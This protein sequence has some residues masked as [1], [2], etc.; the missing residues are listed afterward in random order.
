M[1]R[2]QGMTRRLGKL[3][4]GLAVAVLGLVGLVDVAHAQAQPATGSSAAP[5]AFINV[6]VVPMDS[7][8]LLPGHTVVVQ[9]DRIVEVGPATEVAVPTGAVRIDGAG[10]YLVPGLTDAHVHLIGDG[11]AR[12]ATRAD[13]GD[14]PLYLAHGVTTIINLRGGETQLEWRR[15]IEE[16]RL[17]GPTIY[18]AGEFVNEPRVT[19][20]EDV[21]REITRQVAEGYDVI[22]F[23]EIY[24][25]DAGNITIAGLSLDAYRHMNEVARRLGVPLVGHAP[26][27]LGLDAML[28]AR[29][30][31]AHLGSL[32]NIYFLPMVA[33]LGWLIV[34]ALS[35]AALVLVAVAGAARAM[36][37]R[38]PAYGRPPR[39]IARIRLLVGMQLL[40]TVGAAVSA[41]LFL[42]G[43]PYFDSVTL[44]VVFSILCLAITAHSVALLIVTSAVWRDEITSIARRL[45]VTV[46]TMAS[47]ALVCA[48]LLFWVP[49]AWRSSPAGIE[50]LA[51]RLGDA[52]LPVQTTLVAYD[53]VGGPGRERLLQNP[54]L[55]Y[56]RPDV[57]ERW[58]RIP[59]AAPRGYRYT[60][61]M[62]TV[63]AALHR[64]GVPLIAGTDAMGYPWLAPGSSL[65]R[66]LE[67]LIGSGLTPYDA[68][69][70]A[71]VA[72]AVFLGRGDEFGT[73]APGKRADL[74]LVEGNPLESTGHLQRPLGVMTRGR[75]F[76]HEHLQ[77]M[78]TAL[79]QEP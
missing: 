40:T 56:L 38:W 73:I 14:A 2:V 76:T 48:A 69:R 15:R 70:T 66:E 20:P 25:T 77:G 4:T 45:Q 12:G 47:L 17:I 1:F 36:F 26:V 65:H 3:T 10:R 49:V 50:R 19:T 23:H 78:L 79:S 9:N 75:W 33:H 39:Y 30:P 31:L 7:A 41:A 55:D 68:L 24:T 60:D 35:V 51:T 62:Q 6:N 57:R 21:E 74:L 34:T 53:A 18:T 59:Q 72:P 52:G 44:R 54:A 64:H 43:G 71:T 58:R 42:P 5:V 27:R 13:F 67:L 46:A 16:G 32:S 11:T 37:R 61:F 63:A 28:D 22:K 8:R 29:Q